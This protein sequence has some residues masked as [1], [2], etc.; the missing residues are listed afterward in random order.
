MS[1]PYRDYILS[2][3]PVGYWRL[4][5][6]SGSTASDET[7]NGNDGTYNGNVGQTIDGAIVEDDDDARHLDGSED[8]I[9]IPSSTFT[10]NN[11]WTMMCWVFRDVD[12]FAPFFSTRSTD[13]NWAFSFNVSVGLRW[14]YDTGSAT[15]HQSNYFGVVI[16]EWHQIGISRS[17]DDWKMYHNGEVV[18]EF[19]DSF[20]SLNSSDNPRFGQDRI[21]SV[22]LDGGMDEAAIWQKALTDQ[23]FKTAYLLGAE[24]P[25][26]V[27][28]PGLHSYGVTSYGTSSILD[29]GSSVTQTVEV[30]HLDASASFH[31]PS[32]SGDTQTVSVEFLSVSVSLHQATVT[33]E[34]ANT[35]FKKPHVGMLVITSK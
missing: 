12:E 23:D 8:Y 3:N 2:L 27:T 32:V 30:N 33:S 18:F 34:E 35:L 13:D 28:K 19:T 14:L 21:T 22:Y 16:G 11:D 20:S 7:G 15:Q 29:E 6:A 9:Q 26:S 10:P 4:G 31:D 17:G 1:N 5:E 24:G 25:Y